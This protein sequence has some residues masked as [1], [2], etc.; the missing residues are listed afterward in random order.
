MEIVYARLYNKPVYLV[1]TNGQEGHPW[2]TYHATRVFTSR[3]AF[4]DFLSLKKI[5]N[6]DLSRP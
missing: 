4:E 3:E 2:L 1:V 6:N 5:R